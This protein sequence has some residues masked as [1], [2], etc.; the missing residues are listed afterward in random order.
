MLRALA[1]RQH[2][3]FEQIFRDFVVIF[4]AGLFCRCRHDAPLSANRMRVIRH[5][6]AASRRNGKLGGTPRKKPESALESEPAALQQRTIDIHT[7]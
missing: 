3:D 5:F 7:V 1:S 2:P 4:R 6:Q